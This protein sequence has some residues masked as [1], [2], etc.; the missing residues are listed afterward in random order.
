MGSAMIIDR[1][2]ILAGSASLLGASVLAAPAVLGQGKPRVVVIGG[3]PGGATAAKY[4][5]RDSNGAIDV[6]LVEPAKEFVTCFHS[7]LYLG[8]FRD[9]RLDHPHLRQAGL[10]L[11]NPAQ[12]PDGDRHRPRE[13]AG[14]A[15]RRI[16]HLLRPPRPLAG[17]RPQVRFSARLGPRTRRDDA[18]RVEGRPADRAAAQASRGR[19]RR[20]PDR[21]DRPAKPLS[22]PAGPLRARLDDGA[23]AQEPGQDEG[24]ASSSSTRRKRSPS[25]GSSRRAG[26]SITRA[27]SNGSARRST[28]A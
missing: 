23:R 11:R 1:R 10:R 24:P 27:W 25:R 16:A 12:P 8:G 19:A 18:A 28:R 15:R 3:G 6:T 2:R 13:E 4:I 26:R 17:H 21:D 9:L 20:R 5:A 22:L 14:R 7:N